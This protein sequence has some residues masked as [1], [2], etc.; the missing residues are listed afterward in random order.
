[1]EW[2]SVKTLSFFIM[3]RMTQ[4]PVFL[5]AN[6]KEDLVKKMLQANHKS[7][8]W[9]NY[10]DIQKVDGKWIAWYFFDINPMSRRAK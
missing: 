6:S 4:V 5:E 7:S 9:N 1:M 3:M 8:Q 10:F 2:E